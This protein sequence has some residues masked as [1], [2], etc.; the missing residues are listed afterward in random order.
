MHGERCATSTSQEQLA[1]RIVS[2][3]VSDFLGDAEHAIS[4]DWQ[5]HLCKYF[6]HKFCLSQ[7]FAD[8]EKCSVR[9]RKRVKTERSLFVHVSRTGWVQQRIGLSSTV[10]AAAAAAATS[11][12][13]CSAAATSPAA[14]P[15]ILP[16]FLP[17]SAPQAQMWMI[18]D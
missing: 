12:A 9:K 15:V 14:A 4:G 16:Q 17:L 3:Q 7:N 18:Q 1:P 5:P 13:I 11:A 2:Q 8:D 10:A 6:G